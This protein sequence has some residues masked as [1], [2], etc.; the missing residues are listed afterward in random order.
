M[1]NDV[2][3]PES[4]IAKYPFLKDIIEVS[5]KDDPDQFIKVL[6]FCI[7]KL[8]LMRSYEPPLSESEWE[9]RDEL[10]TTRVGEKLKNDVLRLGAAFGIGASGVINNAIEH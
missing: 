8:K 3:F 7:Y 1:Q 5:K 2:S 10:L 6:N 9:K 4:V